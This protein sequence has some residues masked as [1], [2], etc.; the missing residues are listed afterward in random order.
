LGGSSC[1]HRCREIC[2]SASS[3]QFKGGSSMRGAAARFAVSPS[4]AIKLMAQVRATGTSAPARYGGHRRPLLAPHEDLLRELV[5]ERPDITLAE[6]QAE[7]RRERDPT[8]PLDRNP[9]EQV[10]GSV[11]PKLLSDH[12]RESGSGRHPSGQQT[13][14]RRAR[15]V[16]C[17]SDW[18]ECCSRAECTNVVTAQS[19]CTR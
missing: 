17:N 11:L 18:H 7:L 4:S 16:G 2:A 5:D 10:G 13:S 12:T 14:A 6:I 15:R 19:A 8:D 1:R 9:T 3:K